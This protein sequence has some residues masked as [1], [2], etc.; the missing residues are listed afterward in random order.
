MGIMVAR[1]LR[2][3]ARETAAAAATYARVDQVS[4]FQRGLACFE[5]SK[6]VVKRVVLPNPSDFAP[7]PDQST[8]PILT[9]IVTGTAI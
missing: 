4:Y 2:S 7:E 8:S 5:D 6:Q 1:V 9:Y 3:G